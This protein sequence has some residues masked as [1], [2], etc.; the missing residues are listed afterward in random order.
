MLYTTCLWLI[1]FIPRSWFFIFL[2]ALCCCL[3]I[4]REVTS[5]SPYWLTSGEKHPLWAMLGIVTSLLW[6]RLP[7][8]SCGERWSAGALSG[9][10]R[11]WLAVSR[12]FP[13]GP[14]QWSILW[15]LLGLLTQFLL[16]LPDCLSAFSRPSAH[17]Q[18][19][20]RGEVAGGC[21]PCWLFRPGRSSLVLNCH[22]GGGATWE[23]SGCFSHPPKYTQ[24][25]IFFFI[26]HCAGTH[27]WTLGLPQRL[28]GLWVVIQIGFLWGKVVEIFCSTILML[29][30]FLVIFL[31]EN[32]RL[33]SARMW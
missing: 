15:F 27:Y 29:L 26:Q 18:G 28:S 1:Y 19:R 16:R 22:L 21:L 32:Y 4:W 12:C 20:V 14:A 9:S 2:E 25:L 6:G 33:L 30:L 13:W 7:H 10:C 3:H 31:L 8:T 23:Q 5:S 24:Y 11:A 17:P